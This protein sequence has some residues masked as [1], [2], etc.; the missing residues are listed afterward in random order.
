[1]KKISQTYLSTYECSVQEAV[2]LHLSES[3]LKMLFTAILSVNADVPQ[4]RTQILLSKKELNELLDNT[5]IFLRDQVLA[6]ILI[7]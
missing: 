5:Q 6:G 4:P 2:C 7:E 3:K 1:M